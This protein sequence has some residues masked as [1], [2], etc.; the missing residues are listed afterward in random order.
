MQAVVKRLDRIDD[1]LREDIAK[2]VGQGSLDTVGKSRL[3][4]LMRARCD[5]QSC[6]TNLLSIP[7]ESTD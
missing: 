2:E 6:I 1:V 4:S 5:L 3:A 7:F